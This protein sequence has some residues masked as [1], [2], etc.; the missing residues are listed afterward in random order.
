MSA[1]SSSRP[2]GVV[3]VTGAASG[4]GETIANT[5][6]AEG[7]TVVAADID[8]AGAE[9]V[10]GSL[11]SAG[12]R[13]LAVTVDVAR[14]ASAEAMA[15]AVRDEFGRIDALVNN[16]GLDA[17]YGHASEIDEDHWRRLIDIDLS[18]QWWCTKAVLP[19]MITQRAGRVV[20]ISSSSVFVGG[21]D[22][23]PAYCAAKAGLIGLT[24]GLSS[25]LESH[26]ILVNCLMPGPTGTTGTPMKDEHVGPY[27]A[28]HPLG[29]GGPQPAADAVSYL[30]GRSGDWVSGAVLNVSGGRLR[31]R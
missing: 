30:L 26:G 18:G 11:Q 13:A 1:G 31:G 27:L 4:I 16:G 17:Q 12:H 2:A 5:L 21:E 9:R 28:A 22:V 25:Q 15:L 29:F 14:L 10:A 23:S 7:A 24:V 6:A 8:G 20:F 19:A 3:I